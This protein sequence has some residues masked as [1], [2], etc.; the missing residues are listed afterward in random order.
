MAVPMQC[1]SYLMEGTSNSELAKQSVKKT[2][3]KQYA[4][5]NIQPKT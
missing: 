5:Y 1:H 2:L 4:T 3:N